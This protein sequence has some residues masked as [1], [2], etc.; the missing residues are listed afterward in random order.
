MGTLYIFVG[1]WGMAFF[2]VAIDILVNRKKN[3]KYKFS[4]RELKEAY[5]KLC[6]RNL[7]ETEFKLKLFHQ[8]KKNL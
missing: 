7:Q 4:S 1:I 2:M 6:N 8:L 5:I 3:S